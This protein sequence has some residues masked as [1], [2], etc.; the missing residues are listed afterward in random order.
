MNVDLLHFFKDLTEQY[1]TL[2]QKSVKQVNVEVE[3]S[4][5]YHLDALDTISKIQVTLK[6]LQQEVH[7]T[8]DFMGAKVSKDSVVVSI[9]PSNEKIERA[10]LD[11]FKTQHIPVFL[12]GHPNPQ[13]DLI[14][15]NGRTY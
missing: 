13:F 15:I 9:E 10:V 11:Y 1:H 3:N 12:G 6:R 14:S 5:T 2:L 4:Q 7:P 8:G